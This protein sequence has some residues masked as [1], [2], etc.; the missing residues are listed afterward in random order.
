MQSK[1]PVDDKEKAGP[2]CRAFSLALAFL[3]VIPEGNLLYQLTRN[4]KRLNLLSV[5]YPQRG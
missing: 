2:R 1:R 3:S 5:R 4:L